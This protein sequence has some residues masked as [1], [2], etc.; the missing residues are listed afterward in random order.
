[1]EEDNVAAALYLRHHTIH[2]HL[3]EPWVVAW[4][5]RSLVHHSSL[6]YVLGHVGDGGVSSAVFLVSGNIG[7][8]S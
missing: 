7:S 1:M 3:F 8:S 5:R 4:A 6:P 2:F